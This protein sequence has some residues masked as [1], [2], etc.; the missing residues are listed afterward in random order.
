MTLRSN[1]AQVRFEE[2]FNGSSRYLVELSADHGVSWQR[3]YEG[4][5]R[6]VVVSGLQPRRGYSVRV[7]SMGPQ[8][9]VGGRSAPLDFTTPAAASLRSTR[10]LR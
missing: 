3:T 8:R 4:G 5:D 6:A 2:P 7:T 10:S 9:M 1:R